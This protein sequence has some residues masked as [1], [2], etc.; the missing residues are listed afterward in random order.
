MAVRYGRKSPKMTTT[1]N[2]LHQQTPTKALQVDS[3]LRVL[4]ENVVCSG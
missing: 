1:F 3:S 2:E 4:H